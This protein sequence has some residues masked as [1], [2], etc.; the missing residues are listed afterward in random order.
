QDVKIKLLNRL[1]QWIA[2][3]STD[4]DL[5]PDGMTTFGLKYLLGGIFDSY[6]RNADDDHAYFELDLELD[7]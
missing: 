3:S 1:P 6:N 7:K 5:K 4:S 2:A